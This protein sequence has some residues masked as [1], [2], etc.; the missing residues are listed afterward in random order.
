MRKEG[1]YWI[2]RNERDAA[3]MW[4]PAHFKHRV[5]ITNQMDG[6]MSVMPAWFLVGNPFPMF[7]NDKWEI[8]KELSHE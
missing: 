8:G 5:T 7:E 4:E 1:F 2:F 3:Q 6:G